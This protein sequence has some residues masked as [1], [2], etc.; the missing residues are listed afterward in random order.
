MREF[1]DQVAA[2]GFDRAHAVRTLRQ[3]YA[4]GTRAENAA[5]LP[6]A[7]LR[8]LV[9]ALPCPATLIRR[10]EAADGTVKLLL[11]LADGRTVEAVLM[12]DHD[13]ARAAG[14][15][16]SQAGCAMGCDFCATGKGGFERNLSAGEIVAQFL[17]L[18]REAHT[19]GRRLC[20]LVFKIG[21]AHV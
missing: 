7:A 18:R 3:H 9:D 4:A 5:F 14:C 10:Q 21:R 12:P 1:E 20:T 11:G 17:A 13:P 15:L 6:P 2:W 8:T 19:Q 16:S